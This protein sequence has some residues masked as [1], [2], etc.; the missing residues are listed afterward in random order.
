MQTSYDKDRVIYAGFFSRL[1]AFLLDSVLVTAALSIFKFIVWIIKLAVGDAIIFK[2]I[3][4]SYNVF[5][6]LFY[7]LTVGYFVLMTYF[8]GATVG[9]ALMKLKVVDTE[10][11]KLTFI[12]VL[13]RETVGRYLS[14]LIMYVGYIIAGFDSRKQGLHDKIADTFVIYNYPQPVRRPAPIPPASQ[15]MQ[16]VAPMP[17][18][19]AVSSTISEPLVTTVQEMEKQ[20]ENTQL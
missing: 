10:G 7:L 18:V 9:K 13:I 14:A 12:S 15:P 17:T 3:L 8:C 16:T 11:Q 6:I 5:D 20:V 19:P 2:P 4:F 1:A